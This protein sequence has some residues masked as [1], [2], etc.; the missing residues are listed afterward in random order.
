MKVDKNL[1]FIFGYCIILSFPDCLDNTQ[2]I[3]LSVL[4]YNTE[5]LFSVSLLP[6]QLSNS[7]ALCWQT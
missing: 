1:D 5:K 2:E 4:F 7:V 6:V 3:T